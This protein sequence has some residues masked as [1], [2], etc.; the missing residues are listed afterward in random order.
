MP[1]QTKIKEKFFVRCP[2]PDCDA[3]LQVSVSNCKEGSKIGVIC[4]ICSTRFFVWTPQR[5]AVWGNG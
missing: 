4:P 1:E 5:R 3:S 2:D